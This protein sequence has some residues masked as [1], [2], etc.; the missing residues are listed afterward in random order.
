MQ[1]LNDLLPS[2]LKYTTAPPSPAHSYTSGTATTP[3]QRRSS[4][5]EKLLTK[6][7]SDL[8]A[9]EKSTGAVLEKWKAHNR[10]LRRSVHKGLKLPSPSYGEGDELRPGEAEVS[11]AFERLKINVRT[12]E[13]M[14]ENMKTD[15]E[16]LIV[17]N[18]KLRERIEDLEKLGM[19][20]EEVNR[21]E[22]LRG[23]AAE[24]WE[25][26]RKYT[27]EDYEVVVED[28]L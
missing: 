11:M 25:R 14:A 23:N 9:F 20:D 3:L 28:E 6:I 19:V 7:L 18:V 27:S 17:E 13:L 5:L 8:Y 15:I 2:F 26:A 24:A 4:R 1:R 10:F 21:S 12:A 16:A 22:G